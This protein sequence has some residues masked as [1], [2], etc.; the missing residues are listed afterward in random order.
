MSIHFRVGN[1]LDSGFVCSNFHG[2]SLLKYLGYQIGG[3]EGLDPS[4][5]RL[6]PDDVFIRAL[7]TRTRPREA[8]PQVT[9]EYLDARVEDIARLAVEARRQDTVLVY[10]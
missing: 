2:Q 7:S 10:T 5:G 9:R 4:A 1:D 3:S 6:D 8:P